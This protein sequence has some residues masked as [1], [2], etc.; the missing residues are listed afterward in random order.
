MTVNTTQLQE[1][2]G[3]PTAL[4]QFRG[5]LANRKAATTYTEE[6]CDRGKLFR[7]AVCPHKGRS[8]G[9]RSYIIVTY[10]GDLIHGCHGG[11]CEDKTLSDLFE[12]WGLTFDEYLQGTGH[13]KPKTDPTAIMVKLAEEQDK[14]FHTA[15]GKGYAATIRRGYAEVLP[16]RSGE[17]RNI[18]RLRYEEATGTVPKRDHVNNAIEHVDAK[19]IERGEEHPVGL[20]VAEH[21][22]AIYLALGDKQRRIIK[23]TKEGWDWAAECPVYFRYAKTARPLPEPIRGGRIDV[24][25]PYVNIR[26]EDRPLYAAYLVHYFHPRGPYTIAALIG[27]PGCG[28]SQTA[29][30]TQQLVDPTE[31]IGAAMSKSDEDLLIGARER[32]LPVFDNLTHITKEMSDNLCRMSTGAAYSRRT[33]Y[34]DCD[35]T[36][37]TAKN[38]ILVT[39]VSDVITQA[40]LL[41]RA[42]RF[43]LSPLARVQDED[44]I[45]MKVEEIAPAVLGALLDGVAS[46]LRNLP[47]TIIADPPRMVG[48]ALWG[49]AAEEGLGL[50]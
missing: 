1:V 50:E 23:V 3:G 36:T 19:A 39:S 41:D 49:T 24:L 27:P 18:T 42:L 46:A 8:C 29:R 44:V 33:K 35:E 9:D 30:T 4:E 7:L 48:F 25:W 32:R 15:D 22:E 20:R 21:G 40:D 5:Y 10:T 17:Y 31:V 14:L 13:K 28:K 16:I 37:L 43:M 26:P 34:S 45:N 38:P 11:K 2:A 47:Q 12:V 6:D